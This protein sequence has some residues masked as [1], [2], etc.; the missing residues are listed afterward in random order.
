MIERH[1]KNSNTKLA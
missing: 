1:V